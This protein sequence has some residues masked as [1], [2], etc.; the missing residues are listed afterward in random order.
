MK[1]PKTFAVAFW[2]SFIGSVLLLIGASLWTAMI[3]KIKHL[4]LTQANSEIDLV[5]DVATGHGLRLCWA[6]FVCLVI[7]VLPYML[8]S[9]LIFVCIIYTD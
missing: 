7:A 4:D 3:K 6:A 2:S 1:H 5:I 9:V 8:R